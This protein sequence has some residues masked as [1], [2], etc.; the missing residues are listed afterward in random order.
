MRLFGVSL[1]EGNVKVG[2]VFTFSL[3]SRKTCPGASS[4]C[5]DYCY[6]YRYERCRP[7]CQDAY[8]RNLSLSRDTGKFIRTLIGVLPRIMPCFRIHVGGDFYSVEYVHAWQRICSAFPQV[9]FWAY[10]RSWAAPELR[11]ALEGLRSLENMQLMASTDPA[12]PLPPSG[13]R[14]GFVDADPRAQGM[15]C[16]E[17]T[18]QQES[19]LA[20]GYCFQ[21][22]EG[23][24]IFRVH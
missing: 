24:V 2:D 21:R 11:T 9:K 23:D 20:C 16:G 19:C 10:T 22:S 12:M 17:Q 15:L 1:G 6:A 13:W 3:P 5:W 7:G 18:E 14:V 8:E 4:W